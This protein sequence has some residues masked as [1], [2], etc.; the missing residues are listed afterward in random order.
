MSRLPSAIAIG[1][2]ATSLASCSR[3][4]LETAPPPAEA[5][6]ADPAAPEGG[7]PLTAL[8]EEQVGLADASTGNDVVVTGTRVKRPNL[9]SAMPV[10]T[11]G[12]EEVGVTATRRARSAGQ[13]P[14]VAYM[15][16]V[17]HVP[18]VGRDRF[19]S[20]V[21]NGFKVA[22]EEPVSTFSIDVDT[23]SYAFVR[24][25]LNRNVLPQPAAVRTEE[26]I[27]YFPYDYAAPRSAEQPFSS[28]VSVFPSPS[29]PGRKLVRIGIKGYAVEHETRPRAN[30]VFLIDTS[31]SMAE[32][33]KLPLVQQSLSMLLDQ[34]S[35]D[36]T[37]AIVTY[38]GT[39]GT[40]LEPTS[41][42]E[43]ARIRT[44][45]D[46]L[47]AGGSTAGA[48]GI[49]QAYALATRNLDPKGVNRVILAT[50][51]DFNVGITNPDELKGFVE[52]ER[53]KGVFLSVLGFGMG[54]YNDALMQTL[55]QN[56]NGVAAYID[57]VA[58]ARKTLVEEA[59]STLFPIARDVKIQV[60][61]NPATVAEYRLVGYETRMLQRED[62]DND[63]V[64][65]G[66][67]WS[68]QSVTALYEIVPV[69]GPRA[70]GDL[71]YA[72][73]APRIRDAAPGAEY[74]F[75]KIRYK[76][77]KAAASRLISTP[78]DRSAE[79]RRFADAPGDARFAAGV[80]AFA[81][82]LR[83]G[84]YAGSMTYD[85]VL[86]LVSAAQGEDRFGYRSELVRLVRAASSAPAL[87]G[88]GNGTQ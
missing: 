8:T 42:R 84:R 63:R 83:G 26:M 57:T 79:V 71:R 32:P 27:N 66:D 38:A 13:A 67:V 87:Q 60:E 54:N 41:V 29:S 43:K 68:G 58:E 11:I 50:D 7:V 14:V 16:N 3:P 61:F 39:A 25:S 82:L 85:D 36:D 65:A 19:T 75:V 48:E 62:F 73:P 55:A 78:I 37:V 70:V 40:A 34:L 35:P 69:G 17:A 12:S 74:G 24:A 2:A 72:A 30:L 33:N 28:H 10:I 23:A 47:G 45:I 9:E 22:V 4:G 86:Q 53:G 88:Q 49:R 64:D 5:A 44:V 31:G 80:A 77:P 18:D 51:G 81:E 20:V 52:R 56:G 1:L 15:P 59:T 46:R 21:Q 6:A 76:L